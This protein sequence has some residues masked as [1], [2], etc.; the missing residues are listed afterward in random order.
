MRNKYGLPLTGSDWVGLPMRIG[1]IPE[2]GATHELSGHNDSI[3]L[4]TGGVTHVDIV[5][6]RP[7]VNGV[8]EKRH[9]FVRTSGMID[10]LPRGTTI[11][12]IRWTGETTQ[13][14][15]I[16]LPSATLLQLF[17]KEPLQLDAAHGPIY[18]IQ[19]AH[20]VDLG[21]RLKM[22]AESNAPLGASYVQGLSIALAAYVGQRYNPSATPEEP[23]GS[24][25]PA[26]RSLLADYIERHLALDLSV[27]DLSGLLGYS[28]DHFTRIF[29]RTFNVTPHQYITE[30]RLE[31]AKSLLRDPRQSLTHVALACGF[32]SQS[33]LSVV[34]KRATGVTPGAYRKSH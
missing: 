28:P 14:V 9:S 27:V 1:D 32:S 11:K 31:R 24:L 34:F 16:V 13:C 8:A 30:R 12:E 18:G 3:L 25:T 7:D 15:S 23:Q 4:W 19:D 17:G 20:I 33:H 2:D 21:T 5:G 10:L 22:Q 6:S 29:R 26:Q